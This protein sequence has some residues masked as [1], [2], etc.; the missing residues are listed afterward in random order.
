MANKISGLKVFI[1]PLSLA[2]VV[3][4]AV[5]FI[6]PTFSEMQKN[7]KALDESSKKLAT[8]QEQIQHLSQIKSSWE[9]MGNKD[10]ILAAL[11]QEKAAEDYVAELYQKVSSSGVL[12]SELDSKTSTGALSSPYL[13]SV[14]AA[15]QALSAGATGSSS[16]STTDQ[17]SSS[18]DASAS[19]IGGA[20][21]SSICANNQ[22]VNLAVTGSWD[23]LLGFLKYLADTN[24][25]AAIEEINIAN[26]AT[27][28]GSGNQSSSDTL[29]AKISLDIF[30][31]PKKQKSSYGYMIT[32]ANSNG[33]DEKVLK[34]I[35]DSIFSAYQQPVVSVSGERNIFK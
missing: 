22:T 25:M 5:I 2:I 7:K 18:T 16:S 17:N 29:N 33:F 20:T 10:V 1:L 32:L 27:A 15:S 31:M 8:I 14:L 19:A 26:A 11:P 3:M 30:Y 21:V 24:R 9:N 34:K 23:Q 12:L 28:A 13:C 4:I 6:Q 35:E